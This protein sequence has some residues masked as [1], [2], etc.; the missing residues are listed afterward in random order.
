LRRNRPRWPLNKVAALSR[1]WSD[2]RPTVVPPRP[3]VEEPIE[4]VV[5]RLSGTADGRRLFEYLMEKALEPVPVNVSEAQL[6]E[7]DGVRRMVQ[8][9]RQM[10]V[11][12]Q[13]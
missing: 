7:A 12:V 8:A 1:K 2:L 6:R 10:T 11:I 4:T 5:L 3:N 13:V 9:L